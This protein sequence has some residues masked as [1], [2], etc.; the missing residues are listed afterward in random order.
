MKKKMLK[1]NNPFNL[2]YFDSINWK[3]QIGQNKGFAVF[4]TINNGVRAGV[5]NMVHS[6]E[7][8]GCNTIEKLVNDHAPEGDNS[9]QSRVNYVKFLYDKSGMYEGQI[10]KE[11]NYFDLAAGICYFEQSYILDFDM[12]YDVFSKL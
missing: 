10:I 4:D 8:D 2:K 11:E 7:E 6:I 3:G 9:E 12:F 5:K 1:N